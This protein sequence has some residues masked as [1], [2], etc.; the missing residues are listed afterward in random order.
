MVHVL[1][2][3]KEKATVA[4]WRSSVLL[5]CLSA[6]VT[7]GCSSMTRRP[8]ESESSAFHEDFLDLLRTVRQERSKLSP[9]P[10]PSN[11]RLWRP[12]L[13][14]LSQAAF[15]GNRVTIRN[16]R[17]CR[18]RTEEDYDVRHYDLAFGLEDVRSVDFVV[19]P[20]KGAPLL[21]HTMLSFGLANGRHFVI[22]V[23]ARL[24]QG[25]EYSPSGGSMRAFEIMYLVGD[26]RD[27]IPLRTEV[28]D[29]EVFLYQGNAEPDQVQDLLVDMLQRLNKLAKEP[30]YYDTLTNNCTTNIVD[31]INRL[32]PGTI[33]LDPRVWLPGHSD[34]LAY[35]L[36]LLKATGKFE[37]VRARAKINL[38]AHLYLDD[39]Q[40]SQRIRGDR[41]IAPRSTAT[42]PPAD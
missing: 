4:H 27:L 38:L 32:R 24:E 3:L 30:E 41:T 20:F 25:E 11:E 35:G 33:R 29:V 5:I 9:F 16:V 7:M 15:E 13:A 19:V 31:H 10:P 22:S 23:E 40:F 2:A 8:R 26:E 6:L 14:V 36:G 39:P 42:M 21:A 18:Y 1:F 12:D 37:E 34:R 28:R 17:N